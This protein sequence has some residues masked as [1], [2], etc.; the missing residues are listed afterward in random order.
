MMKLGIDVGGTNTDVVIVGNEGKMLSWKKQLTSK[1]IISGIET[2]TRAV[3]QEARIVPEQIE[4]IFIGTTHVQNAL[5]H[6]VQLSKTAVIR[7]MKSPSHVKPALFWP[8]HLKRYI[9]KV[10]HLQHFYDDSKQ[11]LVPQELDNLYQNL[12]EEN[13][14]AICIAAVNSPLN[15][16]EEFYLRDQLKNVFPEMPI[17]MSHEL[18][19]FGFIERENAALLNAI[20]SK[21][22]RQ[23][24]MEL[25]DLFRKLK[26][27]CPCW[28]TQND[29]SL[30]ELHESIDY[31]IFTIGSGATNS[32]RGASIL[33]GLR[34][35]IVVD[36]GGSTI[37]I[38]KIR[39]G[40]PES[41]ESSTSFLNIDVNL[42]VPKMY[43]L[44][45]GGGSL[46]SMDNGVVQIKETIAND[47]EH[48]GISWGGDSWTIT[49]SFL[50]VNPEM[51]ADEKMTLNGLGKLSYEDCQLV[52]KKVTQE[53]KE[54]V[55]R[56]EVNSDGLPVVLVGGGSKLLVNRLFGKY[57]RVYHP[58]YHHI[59]NAIG[60]CYAPLS[61]QTDKVFWLMNQTK[62]EILE[63][64][65]G[66][67]FQQLRRKGAKE[68]SIKVDLIEEFPFDYFKGEV[69]R[70]RMKAIGDLQITPAGDGSYL[71]I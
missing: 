11:T 16:Q 36:F 8:E 3:I 71:K 57:K 46:I 65:K 15:P 35:C 37:E 5:Y 45:I 32:F 18:G 19:S 38:G 53:I 66:K 31:P 42:R 1:N 2:A 56:L 28:L 29:G 12:I 64:E 20:L 33:S 59:S 9:G 39:N 13:I 24:M 60:A 41:A 7:I 23:A 26:L 48:Q 43:S 68:D 54:K 52:I 10:Y 61:A 47:L 69:L 27:N 67:L 34:E 6:P 44:P 51:F 21:V 22:I 70:I 58:L 30:I 63:Q 50:K 25:T 55:A 49:D 62:E 17:T 14:E 40:Q 4:G